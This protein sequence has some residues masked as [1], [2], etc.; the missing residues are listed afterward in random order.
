MADDNAKWSRLAA[1]ALVEYYENLEEETGTEIEFDPVAI[2]CDWTEYDSLETI[3]DA[4]GIEADWTEKEEA[5]K[6]VREYLEDRT[7]LIE[8]ENGNGFLLMQF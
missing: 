1:Y 2:R 8:L 7:T 5:E 6:T 4:Y 3:G